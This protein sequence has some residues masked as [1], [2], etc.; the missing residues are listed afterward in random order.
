MQTTIAK[1]ESFAHLAEGWSYGEGRPLSEKV[2]DRA[3]QLA[4]S[5]STLGFHETDAFPGVDGE[6]MVTVY[7]DNE[8]WEFT[9]HPTDT[10]TFAYEKDERT[11]VYEEGLPFEFAISLLTNLAFHHQLFAVKSAEPSLVTA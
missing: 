1:I 4:K 8:Y 9:L 11:L 5:A 10:I 2:L 7:R 6:V 3:T